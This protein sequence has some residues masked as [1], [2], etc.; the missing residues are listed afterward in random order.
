MKRAAK[1]WT[2]VFLAFVMAVLMNPTAGQ[3]VNAATD[4]TYTF[5]QMT[6]ASSYGLTY[7][8][9]GGALTVNFQGQYKE[10]KYNLPNTVSMV[11]C[12]SIKIDIKSDEGNTAIKFYDTGG[13]EAFVKYNCYSSRQNY[14]LVPS[15]GQTI[16]A[17]GVMSQDTADYSAT[18][19]SV[20]FTLDSGSSGSAET[21]KSAYSPIFGKVGVAVTLPQLQASAT[22]D[23]I[24]SQYNSITMENEMKPDALLGSSPTLLSVNQAQQN[25]YII[26]NGYT[27]TYVPAIH[28]SNLD[29]VLGIAASNGLGL[30]F[31]TLIWHN[32]TP[33]WFFRTGYSGNTYV[34]SDVMDKRVEYYVKNVLA[35]V[36][37]GS[38][39]QVV[40][41]WDI[42]NEYF[43]NTDNGTCHWTQIYGNEGNSPAYIKKAFQYASDMLT[44]YG[45]RG[46]VSLFYNDYN[47][48]MIASDIVSLI[49][50]INSGTDYCD[51]VGM[52]SHLDVNWPSPS[53]VGQAVQTF[54][55]AG[56]E[57]QLT[58]VDVT[59]NAQ[60]SGYT[61][62][63][64][65]AYYDD[66]MEMLITKKK[67]GGDISGI[68]F[69]GL[70]DS[71]SWRAS[72]QPLLFTGINQPKQ[73]YY[74]VIQAA[75]LY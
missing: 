50:Y 74:S 61:L 55:D 69:W 62:A 58:E 48:Y 6:Y 22:L 21:L 33:A 20:T 18:V 57:I 75:S 66:L 28:Y 15:D 65:A 7:S 9:S 1:K 8:V 32:Q 47:T 10:I 24:K 16:G 54:M 73:A 41:A 12:T 34:S 30:R 40:Y 17:I 71:V 14:T 38:Y 42:A 60:Q 63:D 39:G 23:F 35:H 64:Q 52:Q 27:E 68:T 72:G 59:L 29:T 36:Y 5:Q 25:G 19:Y 67:A 13:K 70:Y 11:G 53:Y 43:H 26:P 3:K 2:T 45:V 4:T 56:L 31:H 37:S 51:G 46:N 44:S 49:S